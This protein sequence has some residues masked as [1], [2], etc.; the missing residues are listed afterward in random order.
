M[1]VMAPNM[2]RSIATRRVAVVA[3]GV[4]LLCASA[5]AASGASTRGRVA[6]ATPDTSWTVY[7][8][9]ALS[10]GVS[11]ALSSVNLARRAWTSPALSGQIYGEPLVY[12]DDVY[13]ATENDV[14]YALSAKTGRVV[15]GRHLASAVPS[16]KLPCGD[17]GPVVGISGTPVIDP[18]R[19][20]IFVVADEL[21]GGGPE[22]YLVGLSTTNGKV[23]LRVH[24]DPPGSTPDALLQRTG[25]NLDHGSVVFAMGGNYGDCAAY[26]GRVISVGEKGSP[27]RIFTVDAASGDS[28]GAIWMGGA[29]PVVDAQGNVW[30]T[31]GN[32]SVNS[33]GQPYDDSD[34]ILELSSTLRLK[35]YF[36]PSDWTT[37]NGEDLD[38][39]TAPILLSDGQAVLVGKSRIAYLL[40]AS[41]LGGIGNGETNLGGLCDQ[42]IDGGAVVEGSTVY[43]PC[44]SGPV[45]LNVGISPPSLHMVWSSGVGGGP[46]LLVA[47]RVWT[48][49]QNGILYG[50]NPASG[51]VVQQANVG[52]M[53]NHFP[54]PSV[55]D[56]LFLVPTANGVVAF[57][58]TA[59]G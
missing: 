24:V 4:A 2:S 12:G 29:A 8:G 17:I 21:V 18:S 52:Q 25:L 11:T 42:D 28:Q 5:V 48:I 15:W 45:A 41:H 40:R 13:V 49:G 1:G 16:S 34:G 44:L 58:G 23:E 26:R 46:P 53:T 7:H 39:T 56:G 37:N 20:E 32:G 6:H 19:S 59:A 36:A 55:G 47:D 33:P 50:L 31:S 30:V 35:Q 9:N 43:L 3:A 10:T 54:T 27:R 57:H 14:V 51:Q 22:H 38:M